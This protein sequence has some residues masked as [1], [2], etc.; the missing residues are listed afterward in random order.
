ML[1]SKNKDVLD[2]F[3]LFAG[4][5]LALIFF[6]I[7]VPIALIWASNTLFPSLTISYTWNTVMAMNIFVLVFSVIANLGNQ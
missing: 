2:V 4:F 1:R 6:F 5:I 7:G 3:G